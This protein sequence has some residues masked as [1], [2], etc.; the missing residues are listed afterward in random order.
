M[1]EDEAVDEVAEGVAFVGV[2]AAGGFELES[3][4]VCWS[5]F[6]GFEEE[7]VGADGHSDSDALERVEAGL[8]LAGFMAALPTSM[9]GFKNFSLMRT[10]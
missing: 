4:V 1:F 2:E 10:K 3:Q 8:G 5:A 7:Q 6:F 9:T